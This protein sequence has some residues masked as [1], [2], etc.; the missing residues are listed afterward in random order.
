MGYKLQR[1]S[2]GLKGTENGLWDKRTQN[3][4]WA[5]RYGE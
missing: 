2:Y 3:R 1:I 5:K 4:L